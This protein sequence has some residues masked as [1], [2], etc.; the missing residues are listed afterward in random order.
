LMDWAL[1]ADTNDRAATARPVYIKRGSNFM[2]FLQ[3]SKNKQEDNG[4]N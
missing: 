2:V 4:N 3:T 1:A